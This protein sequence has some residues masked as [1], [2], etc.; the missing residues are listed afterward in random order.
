MNS[1]STVEALA[2]GGHDFNDVHPMQSP[3]THLRPT[4]TLSPSESSTITCNST[5][6]LVEKPGRKD[7]SRE[8]SSVW[9]SRRKQ[10]TQDAE[11]SPGELPMHGKEPA[12]RES[13]WM[14]WR[15]IFLGSCALCIFSYGIPPLTRLCSDRAQCSPPVHSCDR[16]CS[17]QLLRK[18]KFTRLCSVDSATSDVR[19]GNIDLR[20]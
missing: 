4:H 5:V 1:S 6:N 12:R 11:T 15:L 14:G 13:M 17:I 3:D 8:K 9:C 18:R 16:E 10:K 2:P 20:L 7:S 19:V